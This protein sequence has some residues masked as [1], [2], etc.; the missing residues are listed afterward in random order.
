MPR[1]AASQ[2]P[3]VTPAEARYWGRFCTRIQAS[4]MTPSIPSLPIA[5]RSGLGPAPLPGSRRDSITPAGVS[6]RSDSTKS[7][8]CVWFVA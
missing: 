1:Y 4:V 2:L 6:M 8:M 3:N 7:S 5:R